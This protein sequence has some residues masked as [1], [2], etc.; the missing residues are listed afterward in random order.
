MPPRSS[1]PALAGHPSDLILGGGA[2]LRILSA[3]VVQATVHDNEADGA[4]AGPSYCVE[5]SDTY[6][7]FP[8]QINT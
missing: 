1:D 6:E 7:W 5:T 2:N 8:E 4:V 3:I